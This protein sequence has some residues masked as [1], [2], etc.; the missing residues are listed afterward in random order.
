MSNRTLS[1]LVVLVVLSTG[2]LMFINYFNI[3]TGPLENKFLTHN[4]VKAV[5]VFNQ[6]TPY[7]LSFDQQKKFIDII[8]L[9]VH[10]D[11][12]EKQDVVKGPFNYEKVVIHQFE[13]PEIIAT[14][15]GFVNSQLLMVVPEWDPNGLIR[16]T[17]PGELNTLF[18]D[19]VSP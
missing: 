15:Y 12:N 17:G 3:H 9:A 7:P 5:D 1:L 6:N 14:P 19:A 10:T 16:E 18:N 4:N 13:G 2:V 8:N 11:F